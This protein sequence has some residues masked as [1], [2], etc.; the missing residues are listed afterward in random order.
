MRL[1]ESLWDE[2]VDG[3]PSA[4]L[5]GQRKICSAARLNTIILWLSSTVNSEAQR[6]GDFGRGHSV[7][8]DSS[9]RRRRAFGENSAPVLPSEQFDFEFTRLPVILAAYSVFLKGRPHPTY[10]ALKSDPDLGRKFFLAEF[11]VYV[12][13]IVGRASWNSIAAVIEAVHFALGKPE[14]VSTDAGSLKSAVGAFRTKNPDVYSHVKR[15]AQSALG[16]RHRWIAGRHTWKDRKSFREKKGRS[17]S[18]S[19][20]RMRLLTNASNWVFTAAVG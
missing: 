12:E 20:T 2:R 8:A 17:N 9:P 15:W 19:S 6:L 3:L 1:T 4:S 18:A 14:G 11:V 10:R 16:S 7:E 13:T 5:A